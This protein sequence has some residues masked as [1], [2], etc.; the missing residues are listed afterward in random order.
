M[1]ASRCGIILPIANYRIF[2]QYMV[3]NEILYQ[4]FSVEAQ[5][6]K[7]GVTVEPL[8]VP[9]NMP[10]LLPVYCV[11]FGEILCRMILPEEY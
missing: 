3:L 1:L 10:S 9:G 6:L 11:F 8:T 7:F 2:V 5:G 4:G